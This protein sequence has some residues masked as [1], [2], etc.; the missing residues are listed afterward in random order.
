MVDADAKTKFRFDES[1]P[2]YKLFMPSSFLSGLSVGKMRVKLVLSE[3]REEFRTFEDIKA[4]ITDS[5]N[6][7]NLSPIELLLKDHCDE[8]FFD[9][10]IKDTLIVTD[11][12]RFH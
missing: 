4:Y 8:K 12:N 5:E 6:D 11:A 2:S 3:E 1:L 10:L 7:L 9:L